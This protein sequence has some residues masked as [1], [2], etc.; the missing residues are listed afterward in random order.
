MERL[1]CLAGFSYIHRDRTAW[2]CYQPELSTDV[3]RRAARV[4]ES[5][6]RLCE[7]SDTRYRV[8]CIEYEARLV[9]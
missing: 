5:P 4:P 3:I 8:L 6:R 2:P 7:P 9:R 1:Y